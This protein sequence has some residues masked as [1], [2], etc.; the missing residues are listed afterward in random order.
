VRDEMIQEFIRQPNRMAGGLNTDIQHFKAMLT[1]AAHFWDDEYGNKWLAA[2]PRFRPATGQKKKGVVLSRGQEKA[3]IGHLPHTM[4]PIAQFGIYTGC[5]TGELEGLKW[6][7]FRERDGIVFFSLPA[8]L[9][10]KGRERPIVLNRSARRIVENLR[11]VNGEYVFGCR[12]L[13]S[14]AFGTAWEAA[15]LSLDPLVMKGPHN[16][17]YTF[18]ARLTDAGVPEWTLQDALGHKNGNVTRLYARGSLEAIL[19]AVEAPYSGEILV[20]STSNFL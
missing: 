17:R 15:G 6:T 4:Q 8:S 2:V 3:L 12:K 14:R 7:M 5:R 11:G 20:R 13:N 1:A 10:K 9:T 18:A 19:E 16:F